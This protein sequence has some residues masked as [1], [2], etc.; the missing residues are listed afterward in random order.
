AFKNLDLLEF[1]EGD[2]VGECAVRERVRPLA[3][4]ARDAALSAALVVKTR[5]LLARPKRIEVGQKP[6]EQVGES[7]APWHR[8]LANLRRVAGVARVVG[9]VAGDEPGAKAAAA[10]VEDATDALSA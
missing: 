8:A 2:C 1:I 5:R 4:R 7:L 6:R 9:G 3:R 10:D